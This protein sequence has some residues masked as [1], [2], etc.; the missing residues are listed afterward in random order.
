MAAAAGGTATTAAAPPRVLHSIDQLPES[1][2]GVLLD[3]FGVLHDGEKPYPGAIEAV[4]LLAGRGVKLLIISNSSR[5]EQVLGDGVAS[6]DLE[7]LC[8]RSRL[9]CA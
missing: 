3:Q 7:R 8:V 4:S 2:R 5:R 6:W 1:F 9:G